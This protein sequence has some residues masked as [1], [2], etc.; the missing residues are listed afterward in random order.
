MA[1]QHGILPITG[2]IGNITF[3]KSGEGFMVKQK[4]SVT[5]GR[6]KSDPA[7]QRTRENG[8][9]FGRAGSAGKILR[10]ALR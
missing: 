9:E 3:Y 2:T 6:I 7:Y 5:A 10:T 8:A 1:Q 4:T